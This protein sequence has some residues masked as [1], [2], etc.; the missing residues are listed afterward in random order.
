ML[1]ASSHTFSSNGSFDFVARNADGAAVSVSVT[2]AH[3]D[4]EA[5]VLCASLG[6]QPLIDGGWANG[7]VALS[8]SDANLSSLSLSRNG[9]PTPWPGNGVVSGNGAYAASAVDVLGNRASLRFNIDSVLPTLGAKSSGKTVKAGALLKS[10]VTLSGS[11][12]NLIARVLR[13]NSVDQ[14]WPAKGVV[15]T[16]GNYIA[17]VIDRA[18]NTTSL[19]FT[20]D[21]AAPKFLVS[22]GSGAAMP[23]NKTAKAAVRVSDTDLTL[24]TLAA[25]RNGKTI[26]W[27]AGGVFAGKGK[28]TLTAKD[29]A[30]YTSS[31]SFTIK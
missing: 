11:D 20:I 26:P 10:T 28:Y 2:I 7:A 18:G 8:A 30:G 6:S 1:D 22:L 3:I 16:D 23:R 19:A 25:K 14:P 15:K 13:C 9:A 17:S 5:P 29:R 12:T 27:P 4:R 24:K 31:Y 21:R